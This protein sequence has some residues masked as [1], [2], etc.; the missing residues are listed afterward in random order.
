MSSGFSS[1]L[2]GKKCLIVDNSSKNRAD[3]ISALK[4]VGFPLTEIEKCDSYDEAI[5]L[6]KKDKYHFIIA[7]LEIGSK[8]GL[9]FLPIHL[10][11]IPDRLDGGFVLLLGVGNGLD[12]LNIPPSE[13]DK[14]DCL[15][16]GEVSEKILAMHLNGMIGK[17]ANPDPYQM[18]ISAAN[19]LLK[20][21]AIDNALVDFEKCK[22]LSDTPAE[23]CLGEGLCY[24][25]RGESD[26][27]KSAFEECY[28]LSPNLYPCLK[29]LL[30]IYMDAKDYPKA[31][32]ICN[33]IYRNHPIE[34]EQVPI[35][36]RLI[37]GT[38]HCEEILQFCD[39]V[40]SKVSH[41][42]K[43]LKSVAAGLAVSGKGLLSQHKPEQAAE[44]FLRGVSFAKSDIPIMRTI[45]A[46]LI[47]AGK[48]YDEILKILDSVDGNIRLSKDFSAMELEVRS[49]C[50]N[51]SDVIKFGTDI[52]RRNVN[53]I[54]VY[55][56]LIKKYI[57]I[58]SKKDTIEDLCIE[59]SKIHPSMEERFMGY[60]KKNA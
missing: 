42:S 4:R 23:A 1:Y 58:G 11:M 34:E 38:N 33:L 26:Q 36:T 51:P 24:L 50:G 27:A 31:Y 39:A 19:M 9:D 40:M 48:S 17:K 15:V 60:L 14:I 21:G 37:V 54:K 2:N 16:E 55:E 56:I 46:G 30:T 18:A 7:A 3:A 6:L 44:V 29:E 52:L 20:E 43:S 25:K 28:L 12:K 53:T 45:L 22:K 32:E 35:F 13:I 47:E 57:E 10:E 8:S 41:D 59:A 5:S 49:L